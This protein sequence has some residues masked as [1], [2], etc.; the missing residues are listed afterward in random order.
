MRYNTVVVSR[1][2]VQVIPLGDMKREL[3]ITFD[4]D[5]ALVQGHIDAA[6]DWIE[7]QSNRFLQ[8]VVIDLI[9]DQ[10]P[11]PL[12][13]PHL[14]IGGVTSISVDGVGVL[15]FRAIGGSPYAVL[16]AIG[17]LWSYAA[18]G[19]G[20]SVVR[21]SAGYA[22]GAVPPG[23]ASAVKALVNMYYDKPS[24]MEAELKAIERIVSPYRVRNI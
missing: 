6:I 2:A 13:L 3:D 17:T 11:S 14:P 5:D 19:E 1:S 12:Y 18:T 20:A 24:D 21:Y 22:E 4:D 9:T 23:L 7:N 10:L 8:P 16:P 15:G